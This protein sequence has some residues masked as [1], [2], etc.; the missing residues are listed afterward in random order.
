ME[1]RHRSRLAKMCEGF[2]S[3]M[4][5]DSPEIRLMRFACAGQAEEARTWILRN[6]KTLAHDKN[7][8]LV[9]GRLPPEAT[10]RTL[11]EKVD[12]NVMEIE[13]KTE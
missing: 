10:F 8:A 5:D 2:F 6:V 1:Y 12:G 13:F 7:I 11:G 3:P 9:T 4:Q